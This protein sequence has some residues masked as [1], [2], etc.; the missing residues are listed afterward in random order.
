[1]RIEFWTQP[2]HLASVDAAISKLN[3]VLSPLTY[4]SAELLTHPG[5]SL[6]P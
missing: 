5:L 2:S 6:T 1:M 4:I 3:P